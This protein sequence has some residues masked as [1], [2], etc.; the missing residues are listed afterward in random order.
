MLIECCL[1]GIFRCIHDCIGNGLRS[2]A[3]PGAIGIIGGADGPT[4]IFIPNWRP[5]L[6]GTIAV[7]SLFI[8]GIG[9]GYQPPIMRLLTTKHERLI[10]NEN[11]LHCVVAHTEK[12]MFPHRRLLLLT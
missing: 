6:M 2:D 4:A 11:H 12:V 10:G 5:N 8:H 3:E 1:V 7:S 9:T